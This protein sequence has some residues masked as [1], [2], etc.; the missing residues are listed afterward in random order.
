MSRIT[1]ALSRVNLTPI[2]VCAGS[3]VLIGTGFALLG[4]TG[5]DLAHPGSALIV[6][7]AAIGAALLGHTP[8]AIEAAV[9]LAGPACLFHQPPPEETIDPIVR[10]ARVARRQ[11]LMSLEQSAPVNG[12]PFLTEGLA[13]AADGVDVEAMRQVFERQQR[14]LLRRDEAPALVVESMA[15]CAARAGLLGAALAAVVAARSADPGAL[16]VA[17]GPAL[18]ALVYG[19]GATV[20]LRPLAVGLRQQAERAA[21]ERRLIADGVLGIREGLAPRLIEQALRGQAG[22]APLEELVEAPRRAA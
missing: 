3:L 8:E 18:A 11:G 22:L 19:L 5:A 1:D 17:L 16:A 2:G 7:G 12:H 21:E 13:L 4:G 10:A 6:A 9:R 14:T 20:V 15:S